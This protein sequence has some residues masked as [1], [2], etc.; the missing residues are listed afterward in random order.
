MQIDPMNPYRLIRFVLLA[1]GL[2]IFGGC[3]YDNEA[4]LYP[5]SST[6]NCTGVA[7]SF[8]ANVKPLLQ[9]KCNVSGCHNAA[10]GGGGV[11]LET[12]TQVAAKAGRIK[13]RCVIEK[14]MPPS[15]PLSTADIATLKCW[16]DSGAP[17][18]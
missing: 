3:Y 16:I 5:G 7:A 14:T 2:L 8:S 1:S 17:N 10:S 18:N 11:V 9:S 15:G 6:I 13:Q 12:Y 4:L